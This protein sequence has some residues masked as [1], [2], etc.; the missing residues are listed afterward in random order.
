LHPKIFYPFVF[1]RLPKVEKI[2]Y[3]SLDFFKLR[4]AALTAPDTTA[5]PL[6]NAFSKED[7]NGT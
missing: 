7:M 3:P 1:F 2:F 4:E 5:D 6:N